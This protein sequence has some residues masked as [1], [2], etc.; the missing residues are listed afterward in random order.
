MTWAA[1]IAA[2][3]G[4]LAA[5]PKL[6]GYL[7]QLMAWIKE[8]QDAARAKKLAQDL[9]KAGVHAKETKD[10]SQAEDIL[11]GGPKP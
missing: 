3:L 8:V 5:T 9:E 4:V 1:A 2:I 7:D 6:L 10:T 11:R